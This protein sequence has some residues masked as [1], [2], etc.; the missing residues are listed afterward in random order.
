ML[1]P[2]R[3]DNMQRLLQ[4]LVVSGAV[5]RA[6]T[7]SPAHAA[8]AGRAHH[9][10][11]SKALK[12]LEAASAASAALSALGSLAPPMSGPPTLAV[13]SQAGVGPAGVRHRREP[14]PYG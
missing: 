5:G 4:R 10:K 13:N 11:R 7:I 1:K 8:G 9:S 3:K 14:G 2:V 6:H 12:D